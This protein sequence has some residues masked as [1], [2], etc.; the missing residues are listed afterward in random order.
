MELM[1]GQCLINTVQLALSSKFGTKKYSF[2]LEKWIPLENILRSKNESN[3]RWSS[4]PFVSHLKE[5][6]SRAKASLDIVTRK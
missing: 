5:R 1:Y 2:P 3:T 6:L 4:A